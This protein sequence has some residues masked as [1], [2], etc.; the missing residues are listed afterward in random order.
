MYTSMSNT[1]S[2]TAGFW[3]TGVKL[4]QLNTATAYM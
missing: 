2:S 4:G 1:S 3:L